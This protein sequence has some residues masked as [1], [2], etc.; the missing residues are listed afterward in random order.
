MGILNAPSN[1]LTNVGNAIANPLSQSVPKAL[2]GN[3]FG[4]GLLI[5]E[6]IDG[7]AGKRPENK[8]AL[9]GNTMPKIPF[10]FGGTHRL[11][12][13]MYPGNP[14]PVVH[15][16]G[17][18]EDDLTIKG[19]FH[20]KRYK[21]ADLIARRGSGVSISTE[22]QE[23]VDAMRIRGNLVHIK[24]GELNRYGFIKGCKFK[25]RHLGDIEYEISFLIVG[26]TLPKNCQ[27][28]Q[29]DKN[30]PFDV[31][32]AL[33]AQLATFQT[34]YTNRMPSEVPASVADILNSSISSVAG[35]ISAVTGFAD[36]VLTSG[37]AVF[38]S[39]NRAIGLINV[40]QTSVIR[41]KRRLGMIKVREISLANFKS[42]TSTRIPTITARYTTAAYVTQ[43]MSSSNAFASLLAQLKA[44]FKLLSDTVP[45]SRHR[46]QQGD[47]LQRLSTKFYNTPNEWKRIYDHNKLSSSVLETGSILEIPRLN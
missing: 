14:E 34:D 1:M 32:N 41:F 21:D 43:G 10:E 12:K 31:N 39:V 33:I 4:E 16:L 29:V 7:K 30:P 42:P 35:A 37:E 6:Y 22:L 5:T 46:V 25:M 27:F 36:K 24:L 3:D 28:I 20:D 23:A 2:R 15:A 26:F 17:S 45:L 11:V 8:L 18:E 40:A 38:G 19:R 47:T 13:D 44:R 9:I